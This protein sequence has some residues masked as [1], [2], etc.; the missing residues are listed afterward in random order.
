MA[1]NKI[2]D[3]V[4]S[5]QSNLKVLRVLNERNAGVSGREAARLTGLSVRAVQK[6]LVN[7]SKAGLVKIA[8]GHREHLYSIDR[9][10]YL[11]KA[12]VEKIFETE[13]EFN[14]GIQKQIRTKLK[15]YAV[16]LVQFGST[17]RGE[18]T[19]KSD[20]DLCIIYDKNSGVI[21][22]KV[23]ELRSALFKTYNIT[24]APFYISTVK[25]RQLVKQSKP[26]VKNIIEEGR[27]I[28]GKSIKELLNG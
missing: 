13:R 3:E 7:L 10:K 20:F 5:A 14:T 12:L 2:L 19:L 16:S 18:D 4:F 25:F 8:E 9:E 27:V 23:S 22:E 17:V 24:L 28:A 15:P 6:T 26:P 1:T 11:V 21:E